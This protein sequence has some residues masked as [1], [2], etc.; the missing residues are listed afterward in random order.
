MRKLKTYIA[1]TTVLAVC[2]SPLQARSPRGLNPAAMK[3]WDI[4]VGKNAIPS[5]RYAAEEFQQF[6]DEASGIKLPIV[7][8]VD[9]PDRHGFIGASQA[10]RSSDIGF[11][12]D[13]FELNLIADCELCRQ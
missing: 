13:D 10:M 6:F 3:N 11:S 4:V 2:I 7:T 5:E 9:R 8:T 12:T 1:V